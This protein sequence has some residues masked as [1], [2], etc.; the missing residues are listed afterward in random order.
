ML[1]L[2]GP[3]PLV[4]PT[5]QGGQRLP[6]RLPRRHQRH[7][8][9]GGWDRLARVHLDSGHRDRY[10]RGRHREPQP[11]AHVERG[12]RDRRGHRL[13]AHLHLRRE[14]GR[15]DRLGRDRDRRG[16]WRAQRS[17]RD[18]YRDGHGEHAH[19]HLHRIGGDRL[20]NGRDGHGEPHPRG[21][22]RRGER[23][24]R[25]GQPDLR[26]HLGA[27]H[28]IG[29]GRHRLPRQPRDRRHGDR[30]GHGLDAAVRLRLGGGIVDGGRRDGDGRRV[31][32]DARH[33][34]RRQRDRTAARRR[35]GHWPG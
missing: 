5:Q 34:R 8:H 4:H 12:C 3:G 11:R 19:R 2:P 10:S 21:L 33:G 29:D 1:F 23:H 18:R 9:C 26:F 24:G 15:R 22:G 7:R 35:I 25:R 27:R 32:P 28:R 20:G 17:E 30:G 13:D 31:R 16:R 14:L 6:G